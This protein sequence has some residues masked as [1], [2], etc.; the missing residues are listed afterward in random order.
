MSDIQIVSVVTDEEMYKNCVSGRA[1]MSA[2]ELVKYK[3]TKENNLPVS[4][5]YNN[6][7][8]EKMRPGGWVIFAHQDFYFESDPAPALE[9]LDKNFVYGPAGA[10]KRKRGFLWKIFMKAGLLSRK[11]RYSTRVLSGLRHP[12]AGKAEGKTPSSPRLVDSVDCCCVIAH[13][14]LIK[15]KGLSFD[16]LFD[17]HLYAEDFCFNARGKGVL[18]KVAPLP[19][20][21][22]SKGSKNTAF[23]HKLL[24][25]K[26]K[27]KTVD[28]ASTCISPEDKVVF[29][30]IKV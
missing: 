13:A 28:F 7:I 18:T 6:F 24:D 8:K 16:P 22:L 21:H 3:N 27:N 23:Y 4:L 9:K 19:C 10:Y 14:D 5:H 26:A 1:S 17:F 25:F 11:S 30:K 12:G 2:H 20:V 29:E 15:N